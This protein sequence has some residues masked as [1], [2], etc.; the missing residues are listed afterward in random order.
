MERMRKAVLQNID[1]MGGL[2]KKV[3][4]AAYGYK[5]RQ[6][7]RGFDTPIL[8]RYFFPNKI[9]RFDALFV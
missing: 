8:N 1:E 3:F 5:L 4:L 9:L 6:I 7:E 2:K